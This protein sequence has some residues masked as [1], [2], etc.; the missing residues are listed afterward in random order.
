MIIKA[1]QEKKECFWDVTGLICNNHSYMMS[2]ST[3]QTIQDQT[4]FASIARYYHKRG[5]A[6]PD[7]P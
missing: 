4:L 7:K 1:D 5:T 3:Q 6:Q 2:T